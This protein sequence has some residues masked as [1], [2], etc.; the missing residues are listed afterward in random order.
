MGRLKYKIKIPYYAKKKVGITFKQN[1]KATQDAEQLQT[2]LNHIQEWEKDWQMMFNQDKCEHIQITNKRKIIQTSYNIHGQVTT[3][4]NSND[5]PYSQ[6][7]HWDSCQPILD[8]C[9]S[10]N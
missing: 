9:K 4:Q 7:A 10:M 2:D 6:E 3:E 8:T 5:V 1:I